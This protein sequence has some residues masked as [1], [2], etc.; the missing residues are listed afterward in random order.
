MNPDNLL[1]NT[2]VHY[3]IH[4]GGAAFLYEITILQR[5]ANSGD[6]DGAAVLKFESWTRRIASFG[7]RPSIVPSLRPIGNPLAALERGWLRDWVDCQPHN[8]PERPSQI[9]PKAG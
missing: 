3:R 6:T 2:S 5:L 7:E 9:E 1:A 8:C 4:F